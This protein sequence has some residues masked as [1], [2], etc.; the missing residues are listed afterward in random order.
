MDHA[1][2]RSF[3]LLSTAIWVFDI[4]C[5]GIWD[6]NTA[7]LALWGASGLEA[8]QKRDFSHMSSSTRTRLQGYLPEFRAGR[9][10]EDSWTFYPEGRPAV[11]RCTCRGVEISDDRGGGGRLMMLVE[12]APV[13]QGQMD[14]GALRMVEALRHTSLMVSLYSL[15]GLPILRNPAAAAAYGEVMR[16]GDGRALSEVL[17]QPRDADGIFK[18]VAAQG[19]FAGSVLVRTVDGLRHHGVDARRTRDPVTG[20]PILLVSERDITDRWQ[21]EAE[22][23]RLYEENRRIL[24]SVP[25]AIVRVNRAGVVTVINRAAAALLQ[26]DSEGVVGKPFL[27]LVGLQGDV[28]HPLASAVS[29]AGQITTEVVFHTSS[30]VPVPVHCIVSPIADETGPTG[31]VVCFHD[32]SERKANEAALRRAKERAE[33]G[34]RAKMEFLATMSHEIRTPMNGVIGMTGLL[35]DTTLDDDQLYFTRTIRESAESLLTIIN[36]ILDFSKLEAGKFDLEETEFDVAA[37]VESVIDILSPRAEAKSLAIGAQIAPEVPTLVR[38]DP[39]RLRQILVNLVGNAVKFTSQGSVAV[40]VETLHR[41]NAVVS[42]TFDVTDTGI[43]ISAEAQARLFSMFTQVDASMARRYGGTGLGLAICKRLVQIMGGNIGVTS[44]PGHGS[45]FWV[46][47]PFTVVKDRNPQGL[48]ILTG[49]RVLVVDDLGLNREIFRRQLGPWGVETAECSEPDEVLASLEDAARADRPFQVVILDQQLPSA[50]GIGLAGDIRARF[51][52]QGPRLI[53]ASSAGAGLLRSEAI[54]AGIDVVLAKPVRQ[55]TLLDCIGQLLAGE[56]YVPSGPAMP[57]A[58]A[59][60][61]GGETRRMR[62]LVAEDNPVN[63]QVA[64]RLLQRH[65]H[66]VDVVGDGREAVEAVRQIPYDIVLMDVQMP[67]MDGLE[68][69]QAIR[70][71]S[72]ER[73]RVVIIAMTANAMQGD[74]DKCLA[75]GMDDYIAKPVTR[76]KLGAMLQKWC[77]H[78]AALRGHVAAAVPAAAGA[79]GTN[80]IPAAGFIDQVAFDDL[81]DA[82]GDEGITELAEAFFSDS[83][84]RLKAIHG[85]RDAATLAKQAHSLK[86]AAANFCLPALTA[87]ALALE[88]AGKAGADEA[89]LDRLVQEMSAV[90]IGSTAELAAIGIDTGEELA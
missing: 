61:A 78:L 83:R 41:E 31:A 37:L 26:V 7:A 58:A 82:V 87:A 68:A 14:H 64:V 17:A 34:E 51:G 11:V 38:G 1:K 80:G 40:T 9:A 81:R 73:S 62:L 46:E 5:P 71:L 53:L 16:E 13:P 19:S 49:A 69:T 67:E 70:A 6:A 60:L 63:Q 2:F 32:I 45:S 90:F 84:E 86:G 75:A 76:E 25:E 23:T 18:S 50:T 43:G 89:E 88:S 24:E 44:V 77:E 57:I 3:D 30:G 65:G 85:C 47:L 72:G 12:G 22:V 10:V 66:T 4:D 36:D 35:L 27:S 54:G 29:L 55:S 42:L 79:A 15:D 56:P 48:E 39:G 28:S 59:E 52:K 33:A 8:L 21:A 20:Q 74:A